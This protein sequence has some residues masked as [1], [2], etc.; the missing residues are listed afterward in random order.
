MGSRNRFRNSTNRNKYGQVIKTGENPTYRPNPGQGGARSRSG[1]TSKNTNTNASSKPENKSGRSSKLGGGRSRFVSYRYPNKMLTGSTDYLKIK[2]VKYIPNSAFAKKTGLDGSKPAGKTNGNSSSGGK[3]TFTGQVS[4]G[5]NMETITSRVKNQSPIAQ[6]ILPIPQSI[7]DTSTVSWEG[8]NLS[9][10]KALGAQLGMTAMTDPGKLLEGAKNMDGFGQI[11]ETT[12]QAIL[13]RLT[14]AAIGGGT[15]LVARATGQ[16]MNPNLE[17]LFKGVNTRSFGF[18]F[19]F[20]PRSE[21]EANQVKQIIRTCKK[22]MAAKGVSGNGFFIGSPDVFILEYMQGG[23]S[24][25][26]LNVFKPMACTSCV[27]N[28]TGNQTYST[29]PDG[30]PTSMKMT[31]NFDELNPI[32]SEEYDEG[33]GLRGVGY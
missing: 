19:E 18:D 30:T 21:S 33:E 25:P 2:I 26:F 29:Y 20:A 3:T 7:Q 11:D 12:R 13:A 14:Q 4:K 1:G 27:M 6:I 5:F 16:I 22:H 24:H 17:V 9:P 32:Y 15:N 8:D 10:L 23:S 28:Y 31:L